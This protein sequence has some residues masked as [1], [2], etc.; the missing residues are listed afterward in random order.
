MHK[1]PKCFL[2]TFLFTTFFVTGATATTHNAA[3]CNTSDVQNA[4]NSAAAGDTVVI[5]AGTCTWTSG[6]NIS[7]GI[8]IAGAGSGRIIAISSSTL[9][10][11]AGSQTVTVQGT[12]VTCSS[13]CS[14]AAPAIS[15]GQTLTFYETGT[16]SNNMTGT[17]TSFN[18]GSGTLSMNFTSASGSCTPSAGS[19]VNC[20]RWMIATPSSTV[21]INNSSTVMFNLTA[22]T[23]NHINVSGIKFQPGSGAGGAFFLNYTSGGKDILIHDCWMEMGAAQTQPSIDSTTNQGVVWNVSFDSSPFSLA[24]QFFRIKGAPNGWTSASTMGTA[25]TT[26]LSNFY[27]ESSDI[28]A[29]LNSTDFDDNT[30]A[31]WRYNLQDNASFTTHGSDT[32]N[33]G[34]RHFEIYNNVGVFEGY[35]SPPYYYTFNLANGWVFVRGGT[36]VFYNNNF[37]SLSSSDYGS[38]ADLKLIVMN[39]QRNAGPN[40]CWGAGASNGQYY[41]AP[42]QIGMGYVTGTGKSSYSADGVNNASTDSITYVGDSEP[43]YIWGNRNAPANVVVTDYGPG[44]SNSCTGTVDSSANYLQNNRDYFNGSTAKPGWSPYTYPHPLT[45]GSGTAGTLNP[46]TGLAASVQ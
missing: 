43:A 19:T 39:L 22:D 9:S 6:V 24:A 16:T 29:I 44:N 12:K 40:P 45:S 28:H 25:D 13:S 8:T 30:R 38:K 35:N 17:V 10:L 34:N 15:T 14:L 41:H 23:A 2:F 26:G 31:V 11:A 36:F 3:S 5:P 37:P 33:Y 27:V 7:K 21:L 42:R 18:S 32:S 20:M 46:P 4:I 1:L